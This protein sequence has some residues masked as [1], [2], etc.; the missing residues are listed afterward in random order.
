MAFPSVIPLLPEAVTIKTRNL[1]S[2]MESGETRVKNKWPYPL[3]DVLLMF[4]TPTKAEAALI[5]QYYC[6]RLGSFETFNYFLFYSNT[7]AREYVGTGDGTTT[8]FNLP[9]KNSTDRSVYIDGAIK[10]E[11]T[12]YTLDLGAGADGA[13]RLTFGVAPAAGQRITY[14]FTGNLK[15]RCRFADDELSYETFWN[16]MVSTGLKLSGVLNA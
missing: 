1:V 7:Y 9:A 11:T 8:V 12:D 3:R 6:D 5:W 16:R 13:D 14:N 15:I 2:Q 4:V 10:E